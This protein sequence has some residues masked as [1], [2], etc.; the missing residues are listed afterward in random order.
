MS[1]LSSPTEKRVKS[2]TISR[3]SSLRLSKS[4]APPS[5]SSNL[6][7]PNTP[8]STKIP[9][10]RTKD[11]TNTSQ[12][13]DI[14]P[15]TKH[16]AF[17][18]DITVDDVT[19]QHQQQQRQQLLAPPMEDSPVEN[20]VSK[21]DLRKAGEL[22]S[23]F[24]DTRNILRADCN[25]IDPLANTASP[26]SPTSPKLGNGNTHKGISISRSTQFRAEKVKA[27]LGMK[28]MYI[29][30]IYEWRLAHSGEQNRNEHPGVEGVYN[31]LQ[32][33]RNRKI[34]AKHGEF[35]NPLPASIPLACNVFSRRNRDPRLQSKNS[36]K[37][38]WRMIWAVELDEFVGD[39]R[40][41]AHHWH[42]LRNSRG[43]LWFPPPGGGNKSKKLTKRLHDKLFDSNNN[44]NSGVSSLSSDEDQGSSIKRPLHTRSRSAGTTTSDSDIHLIKISRSKSPS[45]KKKLRHK[46]K[47][48]YQGTSSTGGGGN[49]S[50]SG[51][52]ENN[53]N[54]STS[55]NVFNDEQSTTDQQVN[56][57]GVD[58]LSTQMFKRVNL[59][60][61]TES[62]DN[63][64]SD[65]GQQQDINDMASVHIVPTIMV[66]P[67]ASP[68]QQVDHSIQDV[69]FVSTQKRASEIEQA[70][71]PEEGED[72]TGE[73]EEENGEVVSGEEDEISP[74]H[75]RLMIDQ[76]EQDFSEIYTNLQD[77]NHSIILHRNF[78]MYIYPIYLE[79]VQHKVDDIT[80]KRIYEI[81]DQMSN[82]N[83]DQ[84][85]VYEELYRGFL[86]EIKSVIHMVNDNYSVKID[87]LLSSSDRAISEIN[88]LLSLELRKVT[89]RLDILDS[90]VH[91]KN[92]QSNYNII[93][94]DLGDCE[95]I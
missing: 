70:S 30:R 51:N 52:S 47:K 53:P 60:H 79:L 29:E 78:L 8:I 1:Q 90:S 72:N 49:S 37:R 26:D 75:C 66:D 10:K 40:W 69:E 86:D 12:Y 82:I 65:N 27:M 24:L 23:L 43:E 58:Q 92:I 67:V 64:D 62:M 74:E 89:E 25:I 21:H 22:A 76:N 59:S 54:S 61:D 42:E 39:P 18:L 83:E 7:D 34:R 73:G 33:I 19:K 11:D 31:P 94:I 2:N 68:S 87:T 5:S 84:L 17:E 13:Q 55:S 36:T 32:I 95:Y 71:S 46:M 3:L 4:A 16:S 20:G 28:Y 63:E 80:H 14:K 77:V 85:P 50:S 15:R 44:N 81:F 38:P 56:S 9:P 41:R 93:E 48:L 88:A 57:D 45:K 91:S 6:L 35:P